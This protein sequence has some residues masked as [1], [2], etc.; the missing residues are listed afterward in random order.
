[1]TCSVF[2]IFAETHAVGSNHTPFD[3]DKWTFYPCL[4]TL[5]DCVILE[6]TRLLYR[7]NAVDNGQPD[8]GR[9]SY[10]DAYASRDQGSSLFNVHFRE[11]HGGTG[12]IARLVDGKFYRTRRDG[13]EDL[14]PFPRITLIASV[15]ITVRM[16]TGTMNRISDLSPEGQVSSLLVIVRPRRVLMPPF[17]ATN[18]FG[19]IPHISMGRLTLY[20]LPRAS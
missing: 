14:S 16:R 4:D 10:A 8:P 1:V 18:S 20:V 11:D 9:L 17:A 12:R 13:L 2:G 6:E 3:D 15:N 19:Y 5:R 7:Q